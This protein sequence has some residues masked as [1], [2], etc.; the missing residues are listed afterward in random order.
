MKNCKNCGA[1]VSDHA[2]FCT[3][4][5]N[6]FTEEII[7]PAADEPDEQQPFGAPAAAEDSSVPPE[8]HPAV[9]S[10]EGGAP[11]EPP[12]YGY[13]PQ[14]SQ[15]YDYAAQAA[16]YPPPY[17][18]G[19]TPSV[20]PAYGY[21]PQAPPAQAPQAYGYPPQ[22]APVPQAPKKKRRWLIPVIAIAVVAALLLGTFLVFGDQ[23]KG[24][25]GRS[26]GK[27]WI[28]AEKALTRVDEKS[29][30][31]KVRGTVHSQ[32]EQTKYGGITSLSLEVQGEDFGQVAPIFDIISKLQLSTEYKFDTKEDDMRFHAQIGL[33]GQ[34]KTE[35]ALKI[36]LYN[37][38]GALVI[39]AT[40]IL[41][42]PL[43]LKPEL[44][45]GMIGDEFSK[46]GD[47]LGEELPGLLNASKDLMGTLTGDKFEKIAGD[48]YDI[49]AKYA[50]KPEF[51]KGQELQVGD[52]SQ[53]LDRYD[54]VVK[55]EKT[56]EML[57]EILTYLK[58]NEDLRKI[59]TDISAAVQKLNRAG[60]SEENPYESFVGKIDEAL[61][62]IDEKPDDYKLEF[63]RELFVD[64]KNKPQGGKLIVSHA[65]EGKEKEKIFT[66][67][68]AHVE[69][70][71]EHAFRFFMQPEG[72]EGFEFTSRYTVRNDRYTGEFSL[73]FYESHDQEAAVLAKGKVNEFG[74]ETDGDFLYPVGQLQIEPKDGSGNFEM[75]ISV[76][77][78]YNGKLEKQSDGQHL[79]ASI[80]VSV[81][82]RQGN[83]SKVTIKVDH[84]PLAARD[85]EFESKLPADRTDIQDI[86]SLQNLIENDPG[87]MMR[88]M[89]ALSSL[90]ID[91]SQ[92]MFEP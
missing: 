87:I 23:I 30:L 77:F 38:E 78:D 71:D 22:G 63:L 56:P 83:P 66:L 35:D 92:F 50:E 53:K 36:K 40:P 73:L 24:L 88:L 44:L 6:P 3:S 45:E 20:P 68:H 62:Q 42:K 55:P 4:C 18:Q 54:V 59:I 33:R 47:T 31:G 70:G 74:L 15:T 57:K 25:F 32:L 48:L 1:E 89:Q 51:V 2:K 49:V 7:K 85:I 43:V 17:Q 27:T 80:S 8:E 14:A 11:S 29:M 82:E 52:L 75:P 61:K 34:E 9:A 84:H 69:S 10:A 72:E 37:V 90:G 65:P 86:D 5:G 13:P 60:D 12:A 46:L 91:L 79:I 19:Q 64:K 58:Q 81:T 67:I 41:T 26:G 21:P 39:D 28:G 16:S 76:S